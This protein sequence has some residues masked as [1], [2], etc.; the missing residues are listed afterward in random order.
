MLVAPSTPS[1][2]G[3]SDRKWI[4][5]VSKMAANYRDKRGP[6]AAT[7]GHHPNINIALDPPNFSLHTT[8]KGRIEKFSTLFIAKLRT[9][10]SH[11]WRRYLTSRVSTEVTFW[12]SAEY[13]SDFRRNSG[14]ITSEVKKFREIPCRRNS[15]DT[16]LTREHVTRVMFWHLF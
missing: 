9:V 11:L 8:F 16:L 10:S 15:V 14:E 7:L 13:G 3:S 6:G 4:D 12:H 1:A 2:F 5:F